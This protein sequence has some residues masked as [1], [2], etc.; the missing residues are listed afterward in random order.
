M[1]TRRRPLARS[2]HGTGRLGRS[3]TTTARGGREAA[4]AAIQAAAETRQGGTTHAVSDSGL[5]GAAE[6]GSARRQRRR[7]IVQRAGVCR[8]VGGCWCRFRRT[9]SRFPHR[10]CLG[11]ADSSTVVVACASVGLVVGFPCHPRLGGRQQSMVSLTAAA[12]SRPLSARA[13][14]PS[15]LPSG[16][17]GSPT[18][19]RAM[20]LQRG[21]MTTTYI[22]QYAEAGSSRGNCKVVRRRVPA[23]PGSWT[24]LLQVPCPAVVSVCWLASH[25]PLQHWCI[26][27][28]DSG[29]LKA[30]ASRC[31]L[32]AV[33]CWRMTHSVPQTS[34]LPSKAEF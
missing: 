5:A 28:G 6:T 19:W 32:H 18:N 2:R 3:R 33:P 10:A 14:S 12:L 9:A 30:C 1:R 29:Q 21:V 11:R 23:R 26:W 22:E 16:I 17:H 13:T 4:L 20:A 24:A 27:F 31:A 7:C 34:R 15:Q 8:N 25:S